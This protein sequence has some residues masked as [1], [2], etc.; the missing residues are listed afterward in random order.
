MAPGSARQRRGRCGGL[1][2]LALSGIGCRPGR[3]CKDGLEF[4]VK[5]LVGHDLD[6]PIGI[7]Q[8][9]PQNDHVPAVGILGGLDTK[10]RGIKSRN[11]ARQIG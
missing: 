2:S 3:K 1:L 4:P 11:L 10:I 5:G 6:S 8:A 9:A 7:R